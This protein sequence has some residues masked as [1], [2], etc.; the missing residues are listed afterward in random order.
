M[1]AAWASRRAST[2]AARSASPVMLSLVSSAGAMLEQRHRPGGNSRGN[3]VMSPRPEGPDRLL[4]RSTGVARPV[5][6]A[7]GTSPVKDTPQGGQACKESPGT[8]RTS[9]FMAG[10]P[11]A[12]IAGTARPSRMPRSSPKESGVSSQSD[13]RPLIVIVPPGWRSKYA[14]LNGTPSHVNSH[15]SSGGWVESG[16]APASTSGAFD[17]WPWWRSIQN[18][19][20]P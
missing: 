4:I 3:P 19:T 6:A 13:H 15:D 9:C 2:P 11:V 18:S 20:S 8:T 7:P 16:I 14:A 10:M 12:L 1:A 5:L 17:R